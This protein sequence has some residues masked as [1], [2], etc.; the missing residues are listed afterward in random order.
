MG[1]LLGDRGY[2]F[3]QLG[4]NKAPRRKQRG[5]KNALQAAGLQPAFA[6]RGEELDPEEKLNK[7]LQS[8]IG[9]T[10][11][12]S[13]SNYQKITFLLHSSKQQIP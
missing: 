12:R 5:I 9:F 3:R 2:F 11:L 4:A 6:P 10:P 8:S 1:V 7:R 13:I